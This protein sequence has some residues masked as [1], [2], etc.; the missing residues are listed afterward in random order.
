MGNSGFFRNVDDSRSDPEILAAGFQIG[1]SIAYEVDVTLAE[2]NDR[3]VPN[4][5]GLPG[6]PALISAI[7]SETPQ[8]GGGF[9]PEVNQ[10]VWVGT[11]EQNLRPIKVK[12]LTGKEGEISLYNPITRNFN[13]LEGLVITEQPCFEIKSLRGISTIVSQSHK[14][15]RNTNDFQGI[16][17]LNYIAGGEVLTF[18]KST[19]IFADT[20]VEMKDVGVKKVGIITLATE[21]IYVCGKGKKSG[22]CS[23]NRKNELNF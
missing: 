17:L 3:I 18:E 16:S 12:S 11:N 20:L 19:N 6:S 4:G 10:Y 22:I 7:Y 13:I 21:F 15:I 14:V 9:C 8:E 23:H 2:F 1:R 5:G